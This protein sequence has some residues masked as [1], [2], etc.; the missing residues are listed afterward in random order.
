MLH[1]WIS[2]MF[3]LIMISGTNGEG[4]TVDLRE[5]NDVVFGSDVVIPCNFTY[6]SEHHSN[7]VKVF[8]KKNENKNKG[9]DHNPFIFHPDSSQ[10]IEKYRGRTSLV[11]K[12]HLRDCSL[13]IKNV[14]QD[15]SKL[16]VRVMLQKPYSFYKKS[17]SIKVNAFTT[18]RPVTIA[19]VE[20]TEVKL[21]TTPLATSR[22]TTIYPNETLTH[23]ATTQSPVSS[24]P[25]VIAVVVPIASMIFVAIV[26]LIV[27]LIYRKCCRSQSLSRTTSGY[28]ANFSRSSANRTKGELSGLT[29]NTPQDPGEKVID[30]EPVYGNIQPLSHQ[31][32]TS[33]DM[34]ESIYANV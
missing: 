33:A 2:F 18:R 27:F 4:W 21:I 19:P 25:L 1:L 11:G 30:D 29:K 23:L 8:W 20:V 26:S 32:D 16:Y 22:T 24:F 15:E 13:K 3:A 9:G 34:D 10:I 12:K 31:P 28:Y 6:P 17:V 14:Q 7:D 5:H